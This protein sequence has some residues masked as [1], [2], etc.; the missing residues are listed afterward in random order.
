METCQVFIVVKADRSGENNQVFK[1]KPQ[2]TSI[3]K[4][5]PI[6]IEKPFNTDF[7]WFKKMLFVFMLSLLF[8]SHVL[9]ADPGTDPAGI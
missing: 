7:N 6:F 2:T 5:K 8:Y 1:N 9:G 3:I 4:V